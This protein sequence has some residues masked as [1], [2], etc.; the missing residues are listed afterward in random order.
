MFQT[1][2][3]GLSTFFI[4]VIV[5]NI[6]LIISLGSKDSSSRLFAL[7]SF[8]HFLWLFSIGLSYSLI[9]PDLVAFALRNVYFVGLVIPFILFFFSLSYL[10][11]HV[12]TQRTRNI[13]VFGILAMFLFVYAKDI[14]SLLGA[15]FNTFLKEQTVITV[16]KITEDGY[17]G[18]NFGFLSLLWAIL[19]YG[20]GFSFV[21]KLYQKYAVQTDE[22]LRKQALFMFLAM[23]IAMI[24]A[25]LF[26]TTFPFMGIFSFFWY[27]VLSSICWV[28]IVGYSIVKQGTM[29]VNT[30]T[31][32]LLV[33]A[34]ILLM[35]VGFFV[36]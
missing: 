15:P 18:W 12:F 27:G 19:F 2:F 34:M 13:M 29:N 23:V 36:I 1:T 21:A 35:F 16:S 31:A 22:V 26:N 10:E 33:F 8:F 14:L 17:L 3:Y 20:F 24:P 25:F 7:A 5:L 9:D 30:V 6:S 11:D 4:A 28:S 32:E